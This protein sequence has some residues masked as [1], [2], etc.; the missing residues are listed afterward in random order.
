MKNIT[1]KNIPKKNYVIVI[2]VAILVFLLSLYVR[3]I[4]LNNKDNKNKSI[5]ESEDSLVS[6]INIDDI[7]FVISESSDMI[8]Y[9]GY[10]GNPEIK[11]MERKL[12]REIVRNEYTDKVIYLNVT[13]L[14]DNNKYINKLKEKFPN[15]KGDISDAPMMVY[16]KNGEAVEAV[17]SEFK[18]V[19]YSVLEKLFIKYET[20]TKLDSFYSS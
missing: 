8:L 13:D 4:Y 20:T 6:T 14:K 10:N 11:S 15:I 3:I 19:D 5:F 2:V 18:M 16:I 7:D 17:N 9:I 1:E 12:Y